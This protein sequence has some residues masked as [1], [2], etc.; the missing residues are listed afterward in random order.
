MKKTGFSYITGTARKC[1]LPPFLFLCDTAPFTRTAELFAARKYYAA[2]SSYFN[3]GVNIS[4]L[5][6]KEPMWNS[7]L[8]LFVDTTAWGSAS[9]C[10]VSNTRLCLWMH[11]ILA[12][13]SRVV[14]HQFTCKCTA[15]ISSKAK[16]CSPEMYAWISQRARRQSQ[17]TVSK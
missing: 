3:F 4:V 17:Q 16:L 2:P 8:P 11:F 10:T 12:I 15:G 6:Y 13:L 1:R 9:S 7:L 5:T 14:R